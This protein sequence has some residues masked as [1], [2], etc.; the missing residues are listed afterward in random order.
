MPSPP[1]PGDHWDHRGRSGRLHQCVPGRARYHQMSSRRIAPPLEEK[2]ENRHRDKPHELALLRGS[3]MGIRRVRSRKITRLWR[4]RIERYVACHYASP[5]CFTSVASATPLFQNPCH[6][7]GVTARCRRACDPLRCRST[8][9]DG[10]ATRPPARPPCVPMAKASV[11]APFPGLSP[12]LMPHRPG[13]RAPAPWRPR[14]ARDTQR[15][16]TPPALPNSKKPPSNNTDQKH[17]PVWT[18]IT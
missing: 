2:R 5:S 13:S 11:A 17:T 10:V 9:C 15:T 3:H 6:A 4:R 12:W 7:S 8:W 16:P 14:D 1:R 18:L